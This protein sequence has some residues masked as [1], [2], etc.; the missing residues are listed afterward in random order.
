M[1]PGWIEK[2][3]GA[4]GDQAVDVSENKG[5]GKGP[6]PLPMMCAYKLI[7]ADFKVWGLQ[8]K[9]ENTIINSQ[10]KLF[11][12]THGQAFCML[13]EY[14]N[15]SM[16][17]IRELEEA[18]KQKLEKLRKPKFLQKRPKER[19]AVKPLRLFQQRKWSG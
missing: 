13:D 10:L 8:T 9:T 1:A 14:Q 2:F 19:V 11:R 17:E 6:K 3:K 18:A 12:S 15:L 5:D 16:D 7:R 4:T